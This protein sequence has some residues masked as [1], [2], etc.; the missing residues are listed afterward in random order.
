MLDDPQIAENLIYDYRDLKLKERETKLVG[1][2]F[3][4]QAK[5]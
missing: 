1:M 3:I 2:Q 5:L 4:R